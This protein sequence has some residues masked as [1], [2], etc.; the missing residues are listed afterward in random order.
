MKLINLEKV[1]LSEYNK[2]SNCEVYILHV[3]VD[4]IRKRADDITSTLR[5]TSWI[6]NLTSD[7]RLTY[8]ARAR[9]TINK[10][11]NNILVKVK[12]WLVLSINDS[13]RCFKRI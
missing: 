8:E 13:K 1:N 7:L 10:I 12:F 9:R 5:N 3:K 6:E 2:I 11:I 4:D